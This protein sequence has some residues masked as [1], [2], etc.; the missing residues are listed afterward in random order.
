MLAADGHVTESVLR[1]R[2]DAPPSRASVQGF[3]DFFDSLLGGA[4]LV[5]LSLALGGVAFA[6]LVVP[7]RTPAP[8]RRARA[9][10][11]R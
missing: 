2:V 5:A 10:R 1:F 6:L 3:A 8:R 11:R 7:R 4:I 9:P